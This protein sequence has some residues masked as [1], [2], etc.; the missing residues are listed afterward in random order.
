LPRGRRGT[1]VI[2]FLE[3]RAE[4]LSRLFISHSSQNDDWAIALRDW[5][6]REGV[7]DSDIFLDLD[8]VRGIAAGEHWTK[9]LED[10]A[11]RCE[12]VL[13]V[14][15][16]A[17]L[18]SKW[19]R[20][21]YQLASQ[22]NK[23][24]FALLTE[25]IA[26]ERLPGGLSAQWQVVRLNGEPTE[27][28]LTI[29]PL[30]Q[31]QAPVSIARPGLTSLKRGLEKAGI[32]AENFELQPDP[33][34]PLGWRAPYRGLEA[35]EPEDAA[36][37]FGRDADV[38]RGI[39]TLRGLAAHNPPRLL[40]VLGASGVGKSSFLRAGLWPRLLRDDS[41]WLP[42]KPI[43]ASRGGAI[44]GTEGLIT[45][46]E[47]VYR[48]FAQPV[49]RAELRRN[50]ATPEGFIDLLWRL[51][52]AGARRALIS[53]PPFPLPVLCVDQA[54]ELFAAAAGAETEQLLLLV[55]AA[56]ERDVALALA[57]IRSNDFGLVQNAPGLAGIHPV[58]LSLG[59]VPQSELAR[60]ISEPSLVFRRKCGLA[61][62]VFDA[63]VIAQLANE[64]AGEADSLPLLAFVLERL[65]REHA[66]S[67]SIG[68]KE[69]EE[70]GGVTAAIQS[71]AAAA[72]DDAGVPRDHTRRREIL[73]YLFIPRLAR[74]NRETKIPQRH[75]ARYADL[76]HELTAL[77]RALTQRRLLVVRA[78]SAAD[79][80]TEITRPRQRQ[81]DPGGTT[82]ARIPVLATV[83][84]SDFVDDNENQFRASTL[85]VAH[86]AL[87]RRWPTLAELLRE[88]RDALLMLD[89][90]LSAA[91]DWDKAERNPDYLAHHG[92]RLL[93]ANALRSRGLDWQRE[94]APA[95]AYFIAC[96]AQEE[97]DREQKE[98]VLAR[99]Q[100]II[101]ERQRIV[102]RMQANLLAEL[103]KAERLLHHVNS[104]LRFAIHGAHLNADSN[105]P[106]AEL[107]AAAWHSWRLL[108]SGHWGAVKSAA[109]SPD[110][111]LIVTASVDRTAS[112]WDAATGEEIAIL[113]GPDTVV[114]FADFS[115][116]SS[117]I[118]TTAGEQR[119][120]A[121]DW[122]VRIWECESRKQVAVL[123]GHT[124]YVNMAAFSPD[125]SRLVTAS[126]DKTARVW[127][128]T[129]GHEIGRFQRNEDWE[130]TSAAFSPDGSRIVVVSNSTAYTWHVASGTLVTELR[131]LKD[132]DHLPDEQF[133][134]KGG[135]GESGAAGHGHDHFSVES[136]G[137]SPDGSRIVT[138][139]FDQTARVWD[140]S[141]G[142]EVVV[143]K[144]H[145]SG[146]LSAKF[147]SDGSLIVTASYDRT[148]R[149]WDA[150]TGKQIAVLRGH[151]FGVLS[152]NFSPDGSRIVTASG[153]CT[154]CVWDTSKQA[155]AL[156]GEASIS[157]AAFSPDG[158]RIATGAHDGT[159]RLWDVVTG[160]EIAVL[161]GDAEL[162]GDAD[163]WWREVISAAFSPN[164]SRI[165]TVT[166]RGTSR[167]SDANSGKQ[168]AVLGQNVSSAIFSPN[169]CLVLTFSSRWVYCDIREDGSVAGGGRSGASSP[170]QA[171]HGTHRIRI[172]TSPEKTARVWDA[173]RGTEVHVLSG[174][175]D[176]V[177]AAAFSPDNTKLIT[178]SN[179]KTVRIWDVISGEQ[180]AIA[181]H[182]SAVS[183]VE[184]SP[185]GSQIISTS[186]DN[187]ARVWDA[188]TMSVIAVLR[189]AE[190]ARFS[191]DG[192]RIITVRPGRSG[193]TTIRN[194]ENGAE[195]AVINDCSGVLTADR[196]PDRLREIVI[197]YGE[198]R[199]VLRS[200]RVWDVASDK[201]IAV[202]RGHTGRVLHAS[203]SPDCSRIATT[204]D[205][206]TTRIWETATGR[207]I[208]SL[209]APR[210]SGPQPAPIFS[211]DSS[212]MVTWPWDGAARVWDVHLLTM[213]AKDLI[214]E[215]ST[216]MLRGETV[217]TR[218]E[219]RLAGYS[220]DT[221]QIDVC[222]RIA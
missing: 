5:L 175:T 15:S 82:A 176:Y 67:T 213:S 126:K 195:I 51:R 62:P 202:L 30:T 17:W 97:A 105:T 73:R 163:G 14:V 9:A 84:S 214:A 194:A 39:D 23:K 165:V 146:V 154:A 217:L 64:V 37:F 25:D 43:R 117:L 52:E 101:A 142:K 121:T 197:F 3:T 199:E 222:A 181:Q 49:N 92:S 136:A 205:D 160:R 48:R 20:D 151:A 47:G 6:V 183:F 8:P 191:P 85:E 167:L 132:R 22:F 204:S 153:D 193:V 35:L 148:A 19:C 196:S 149:I 155:G 113:G 182:D 75:V 40:V 45:A 41:Q 65:M 177:N 211:P 57:T 77:A 212:R 88:D 139:G 26:I 125:S 122:T 87:L 106:T 32:G 221:P 10:A 179:D 192:S 206:E 99:E 210:S 170:P 107:A 70:T 178:A 100:A 11:T 109:F 108:L 63:A 208:A 152:A 112:I 110:G 81:D 190:S 98:A 200:P 127:D 173:E 174:H 157:C 24:L 219:M 68:V 144:G 56:V 120:G 29:H 31:H 119:S 159:A 58:S 36:V 166:E 96:Q 2:V 95:S 27:R 86:E 80:E 145:E 220:D 38:V 90:V 135:G 150:E 93:D 104:A 143:L 137:I 46:L 69:L 184:Y 141:T 102:N 189:D 83:S 123:R 61:A 171:L 115:P 18:A 114:Q 74:I 203:L 218:D 44:E 169:G 147:N 7:R 188:A 187:T 94:L 156:R 172:I 34:G 138:A 133:T 78:A 4:T 33:Q 71:T 128:A 60:V 158:S 79:I 209:P 55:R 12:V 1:T 162:S 185:N 180:T 103:A 118:V 161:P 131:L 129:T 91:S 198:G 111:L 66:A 216:R 134:E 207:E 130:M 215:V 140:L 42:I 168:I 201:E 28:F 124:D 186:E 89:G 76:P 164:G 16:D 21:E 72:L 53:Q 13:F 116:D 59:P 54:E 50:L